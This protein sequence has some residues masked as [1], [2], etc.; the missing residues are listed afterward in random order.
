[1]AVVGVCTWPGIHHPL[2]KSYQVSWILL[3]LLYLPHLQSN[4][5]LR[6]Q[7]GGNQFTQHNSQVIG[8]SGAVAVRCFIC[9]GLRM[10][11]SRLWFSMIRKNC[12]GKVVLSYGLL[13]AQVFYVLW[14]LPQLFP[15]GV[16]RTTAV[17]PAV[18]IFS[19]VLF[20]HFGWLFFPGKINTF[21]LSSPSL[22]LLTLCPSWRVGYYLPI[23]LISTS[24][25][26][27]C[28]MACFRL[29]R[30]IHQ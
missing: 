1:M 5:Y 3:V 16:K 6:F 14:Y 8:L 9:F 24:H 29:C 26:W 22:H 23:I 19:P 12:M 21:K 2:S 25:S 7:Y 18:Y 10:G 15:E 28:L 20:A 4:Y 27:R 17:G 30:L 11:R 13:M